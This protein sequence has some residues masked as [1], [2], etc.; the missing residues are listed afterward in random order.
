MKS[1]TRSR[2]R[3]A[4]R[5]RKSHFTLIELSVAMAVFALMMLIMMQFFSTAQ[6]A[7]TSAAAKS[8]VYDN[9][10]T[11][12]D[13]MT[14]DLQ[15]IYYKA[16]KNCAPYFEITGSAPKE[17]LHFLTIT[18]LADP[19]DSSSLH[20]IKYRLDSDGNLIRDVT[21]DS[22]TANYDCDDPNLSPTAVFSTAHIPTNTKDAQLIP[23]VTDLTFDQ[24]PPTSG[25]F[26]QMV[27]I[28]MTLLDKH[29]WK[30]WK[31]LTGANADRIKKDR[32]RTFTKYVF[33]GEREK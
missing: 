23:R 20:E 16:D 27:R 9:A 5:M 1:I 11:A 28:S 8:E 4:A 6:K 10:R 19:N 24:Y 29:S 30:K 22:D 21:G 31:A 18:S 2:A 14:R 17:E 12:L 15:C 13:I 3:K 26:P 25:A 33:I 7:W 32:G